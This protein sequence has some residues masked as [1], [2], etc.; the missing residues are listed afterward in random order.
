MVIAAGIGLAALL[1]AQPAQ[2]EVYSWRDAD[3]V[4]HFS[5][6]P[7]HA[8]FQP[9][10]QR[11]PLQHPAP[12]VA[13]GWDRQAIRDEIH[14]RSG[15]YRLDP[16]LVENVVRVE[17]NFDPLAVSYKGAMG[18]MQLMPATA[19]ELGVR[20]PFDPIENLEGGMRYLRYLLDRFDERLD[21]ALAAYHAGPTR[22]TRAQGIPAID[23]TQDYVRR[24]LTGY[25]EGR[26]AR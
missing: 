10:L 25:L 11:T 2:A 24:V 6:Y 13:G 1:V 7:K 15:R 23:S 20:H 8:G 3:G 9:L 18:L 16:W 14:R 22:V 17:S 26:R 19:G 4:L 5:D 21:W 12:R